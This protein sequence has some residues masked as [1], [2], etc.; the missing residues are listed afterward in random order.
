M[1]S[2]VVPAIEQGSRV[3]V[4]FQT[5]GGDW[6]DR[7][8]AWITRA[9]QPKG[10]PIY[11][12]VYWRKSQ[13]A[14]KHARP[15]RPAGIKV[16]EVHIGISSQEPT[17]A[18]YKHFEGN[19]LPR[20]ASLVG[21]ALISPQYYMS[22]RQGYNAVQI[23]AVM[24]HAYYGSFGYQ[25]TSFFAV[26]SRYDFHHHNLNNANFLQGLGRPRTSK[27]SLTLRMASV[28]PCSLTSCTAMHP[29][30]CSTASISLMAPMHAISMQAG[31][32][33]TTRYA[34]TM[35]DWAAEYFTCLVGQSP[36]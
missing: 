19:V 8:P 31:A 11:D 23:M 20:I 4:S 32:G 14:W 1:W 15:A 25:V 27:A 10:S 21:A 7:I 17:I 29:R 9:E 34:S 2:T 22:H 16:Y 24:E 12:G 30:T 36:V 5:R 35:R 3:K 33:T 6:V 28:S 13:F 18:S 26:S